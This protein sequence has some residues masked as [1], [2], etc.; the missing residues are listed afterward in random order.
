M[1]NNP[2][3]EVREKDLQGFKYFDRLL[4]LLQRLHDVGTERDKAHNRELFFDQY[5]TLVLLFFFNP[6]ITSMRGLQQASDLAKVQKLLGV[7]RI[8]LG[9][10]SEAAGVF[11]AEPLRQIVQELAARA[12]PL[13]RGCEAEALRGLN[14]VEVIQ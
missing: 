4:P 13:Q 1:A 11:D 12:V 8:S 3:P 5:A 9:S 10:F 14:A 2:R 7:S 6:I